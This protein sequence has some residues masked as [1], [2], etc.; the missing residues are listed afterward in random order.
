RLI[1]LA[2][3]SGDR[4]HWVAT[5]I[6]RLNASSGARSTLEK[7]LPHLGPLA[8]AFAEDLAEQPELAARTL[9]DALDALGRAETALTT[10]IAAADVRPALRSVLG[11][12][13]EEIVE[14][15][16]PVPLESG[17][18]E[19]VHA[20]R[21]RKPQGGHVEVAIKFLRSDQVQRI[22]DD[23]AVLRWVARVLERVSP[24]A[25]K[26]QLHALAESLEADVLRRF[27]LRAEAA[28]LS[29]TGRHFG[30]DARLV[31]P[32]VI[33]ELST[34]TTLA[35]QRLE[36]LPIM[37][38]DGLRRR[39]VD[40]ARLAAHLIGVVIEQAFEHGF[41]HAALDARHIRVSVEPDTI[42]RLVL[43]NC[44]IM[45]SLAEP[46]RE[47]FVHGATALF[48]RDYGRLADMH[49][50]HGHV[51]P[52]TRK[53]VLEAELRTRSE[54]HF[55]APRQA[56]A[57]STLLTHVLDSVQPFGGTVS[58]SLMLAQRA[59]AQAE[60]LAR[61]LEPEID[62]WT[63]VKDAFAALARQDVDH[64]GWIKRLSRELP[65]LASIVPRLPLLI[66]HRLHEG[67]ARREAFDATAWRREWRDEE[68][69]TRWM[70]WMCAIGGALVGALAV[71]LTR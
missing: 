42:G 43:A 68:R 30:T 34:N 55:A 71:L 64:R 9:H 27:D 12:S 44:S 63:V 23:A 14:S 15:I 2:A 4:L 58:P 21:L 17:I 22:R 60:S 37:D 7:A 67:H 40:I 62:T 41:F 52:A 10:P 33:W 50:E 47:F 48:E 54:A 36:T 24:A 20:A 59:L 26:Y 56:R 29:Q 11:A 61:V 66:A 49:R 32:D 13:F 38:I 3:P 69:R 35:M 19:Q 31:V 5:L 51:A 8:S 45:S 18:A 28:N 1:W 57:S 6:A 16:D 70:L 46:E 39:G 25:R 65:H 53:E